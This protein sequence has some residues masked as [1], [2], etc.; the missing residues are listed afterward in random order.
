MGWATV[1]PHGPNPW[2]YTLL[3]R[4]EGAINFNFF[5]FKVQNLAGRGQNASYNA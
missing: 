4:G 3:V 2:G 1:G 5:N